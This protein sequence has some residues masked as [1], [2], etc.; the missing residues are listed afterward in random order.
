MSAAPDR[1]SHPERAHRHARPDGSGEVRGFHLVAGPR[2]VSGEDV[3]GRGASLLVWAVLGAT[4]IVGQIVALAVG[5]GVSAWARSSDGSPPAAGAG[6]SSSWHGCFSGGTPSPAERPGRGS[7]AGISG[8]G[9]DQGQNGVGVGAGADQGG[10]RRIETAG[11]DGAELDGR[12]GDGGDA[13]CSGTKSQG[14]PLGDVKSEGHRTGH[15]AAGRGEG[16]GQGA[17]GQPGDQPEAVGGRQ[18][19]PDGLGHVDGVDPGLGQSGGGQGP[20]RELPATQVTRVERSMARQ[21]VDQTRGR[22][23]STA[24]ELGRGEAPLPRRP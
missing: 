20:G 12:P 14:S 10:G 16:V 18:S 2:L 5:D 13:G 23:T 1:P 24:P 15:G 4:L 9:A 3:I 6:P 11:G 8:V 21:D 19:D 7:G 22:P 17:P